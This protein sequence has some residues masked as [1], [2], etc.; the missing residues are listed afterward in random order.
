MA[1]AGCQSRQAGICN[2][3]PWESPTF[4]NN[5]ALLVVP[6]H[7]LRILEVDGRDVRGPQITETHGLRGYLIPAGERLI[8]ASFRYAAPV[9]GGLTGEIRGDG[10]RLKHDFQAG[11]EYVALYR[12]HA[13]PRK[14]SRWW[15]EH[16]V[17]DLFAPQRYYWTM[18]IVA[19]DEGAGALTAACLDGPVAPGPALRDRLDDCHSD[20]AAKLASLLAARED[21]APEVRQALLY[22]SIPAEMDVTMAR[23]ERL[24]YSGTQ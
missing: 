22:R 14:P 3:Q 18:E 10:F 1:A 15:F 9:S 4:R 23:A 6:A 7:E 21:L 19:L 2:E 17:N 20:L 24:Y 13:H 8:T 5:R 11:R 16:L 12:I